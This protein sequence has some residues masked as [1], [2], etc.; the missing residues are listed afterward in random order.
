MLSVVSF[1]A[2]EL[3]HGRTRLESQSQVGEGP[4]VPEL[5]CSLPDTPL[6]PPPSQVSAPTPAGPPSR[7]PFRARLVGLSPEQQPE[8]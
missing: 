4:L 5:A 3:S 6:P 7:A 8:A 2:P 1:S